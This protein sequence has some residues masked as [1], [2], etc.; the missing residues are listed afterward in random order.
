MRIFS[1]ETQTKYILY[2]DVQIYL[3]LNLNNDELI[4]L[5]DG[6]S[7]CLLYSTK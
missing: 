7:E 3:F 6:R 1:N 5:V 4:I 2:I